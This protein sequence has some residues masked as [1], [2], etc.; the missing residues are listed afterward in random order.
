MSTPNHIA[1]SLFRF[2]MAGFLS[3]LLVEARAATA[4]VV[5]PV[6]KE[7]RNRVNILVL[8][9]ALPAAVVE[10]TQTLLV[11]EFNLYR[12][13][14][15][16]GLPHGEDVFKAKRWHGVL[17][18]VLPGEASPDAL[19]TLTSPL[20]DRNLFV[21]WATLATAR[22]DTAAV[23]FNDA[24]RKAL[25]GLSVTTADVRG[26]L[27]PLSTRARN[28]RG[29][30]TEAGVEAAAQ[31]LALAL[32][33]AALSRSTPW[34]DLP[35]SETRNP[36]NLLDDPR[37]L[38]S[39]TD[40]P[41]AKGRTATVYRAKEG[42][43]QFNLHSFLAHHDGEFWAVWSSGHVDEDG[44][45]QL[46]RYATST[47]GY[48]W[49][50]SGI[51][52]DDPDGP[53]RLQRWMANGIYVENGK[54][55]A[56]AT[57]H[58][59]IRDGMIWANASLIRFVWTGTAWKEDRVVADDCLVY[60]P[61]IKVNDRDFVVWRNS[62]GHFA[63]ALLEPGQNRW[64]VTKIP[65]PF[66]DYRL[67]ET[68]HYVDAD[69][70]LHLVMR[71]QGHTGYLYHSVS[72]DG[73]ATWTIPVRT[74]YPDAESKN[75]ADR[76]SNGWF[77]L[78]NNPRQERPRERDPLA[79]SFSR[80]GWTFGRPFALRKDAP[81]QR[82]TGKHKNSYSFQYSHAIEHDGK[83]WVI[84]ATNKEDIEVSSYEIAEFRLGH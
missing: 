63:T 59:G 57:R 52:V 2:V 80:D 35:V 42:D 55:Y 81:P 84:Y 26:S 5:K 14:T 20:Q 75:F 64:K 7:N 79:I 74:N 58:E 8:G 49:S 48:R 31:T 62:K 10:R 70:I 9:D 40:L 17:L 60:F 66:P 28:D 18:G 3:L 27:L 46:V 47:D 25:G 68:T 72:Y 65:G 6:A 61:P 37:S 23:R 1:L 39:P 30:L 45:S 16:Q 76:L 82:Y 15:G 83:L 11:D 13:T 44:P 78:I 43:Y 54:L 67:S 36:A 21:T 56:L 77:Y 50:E 34:A 32:R 4:P 51:L 71:E 41:L 53:E 73:G 22:D 38:A 24:A 19:R 12:L 69:G 33:K 29:E